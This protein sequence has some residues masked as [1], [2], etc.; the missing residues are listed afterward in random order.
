MPSR[1][2][3]RKQDP[4]VEVLGTR[5]VLIPWAVSAGPR[6]RWVEIAERQIEPD[7]EG[8]F[9]LSEADALDPFD[10]D[11]ALTLHRVAADVLDHFLTAMLRLPPSP[12]SLR[13][14]ATA[15]LAAEDPSHRP[16][17][18][19]LL[20]RRGLP[21]AEPGVGVASVQPVPVHE[22]SASSADRSDLTDA[23]VTFEAV[24]GST[25]RRR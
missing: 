11:P 21:F 13:H 17:L 23:C 24:A 2:R 14:M 7:V 12:P 4:T 20:N 9:L 5:N 16:Q 8:D 15:W 22:A 19:A 10:A 6:D 1:M 18:R 25:R 3:M